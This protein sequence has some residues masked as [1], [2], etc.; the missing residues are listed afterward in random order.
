MV[1]SLIVDVEPLLT[2]VFWLSDMKPLELLTIWLKT[3]GAQ[4]GETMDTLKLLITHQ[5][6][7]VNAVSNCNLLT[8]LYEKINYDFLIK[9]T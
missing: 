7:L 2:T 6:E 8:Q 1:S 9:I 5:P 3:H 4:V